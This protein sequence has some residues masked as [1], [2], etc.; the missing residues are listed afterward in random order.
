[1]NENKWEEF[2]LYIIKAA[3]KPGYLYCVDK[4]KNLYCVEAEMPKPG[5]RMIL[6]PLYMP[7]EG[8]QNDS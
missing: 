6:P 3:L 5:E 1:M 2:C 7:K 4:E 8:E